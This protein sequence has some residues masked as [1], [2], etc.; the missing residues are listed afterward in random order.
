M[1]KHQAR[2]RTGIPINT[3]ERGSGMRFDYLVVNMK[4]LPPKSATANLLASSFRPIPQLVISK[5]V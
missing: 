4:M 3:R 2:L 1:S 5:N